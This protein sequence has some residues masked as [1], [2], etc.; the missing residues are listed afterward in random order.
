[1]ST[2]SLIILAAGQGE[3]LRPLTKDVPKCMVQLAGQPLVKWQLIAARAAG[4]RQIRVVGGYRIDRLDVPEEML[5]HNPDFTSSGG[6]MSLLCAEPHFG[7]S[8]IAAEGGIVYN[9]SVMRSLIESRGD[10]NIVIDRSWRGYWEQRTT[11]V[12]DD[13]ESL[14]TDHRGLVATIGKRVASI[15]DIEGQFSGLVS[16]R[17]DGIAHALDLLAREREAFGMDER[18]ITQERPFPELEMTDLLQGLIDDGAEVTPVWTEGGWLEIDS[19]TDLKLAS[20][21]VEIDGGELH[22]L[23]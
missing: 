21:L 15:G 22:I 10:I 6:I 16:F 17:R 23:R 9:S 13:A 20:E 7:K 12:L 11:N 8:F 3:Q 2:P 14:A 19:L 4:I 5:I 1:M 18:I